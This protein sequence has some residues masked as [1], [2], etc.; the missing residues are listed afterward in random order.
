MSLE[1]AIAELTTEVAN[2]TAEIRALK[3]LAGTLGAPAPAKKASTKKDK[4]PEAPPA[5]AP[6]P[7]PPAAP[8]FRFPDNEPPQEPAPVQQWTYESVQNYASQI[9]T[10]LGTRSHELVD[11]L[12]RFG[13]QRLSQLPEDKYGAF[14]QAMEALAN[15]GLL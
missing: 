15:G 13:V 8:V 11:L 9:G 2:L 1:A 3:G 6:A 10:R 4:A 14:V 7:T 5:A 12:A